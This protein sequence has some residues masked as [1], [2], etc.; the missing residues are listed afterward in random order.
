MLWLFELFLVRVSVLCYL[1]LLSALG[2]VPTLI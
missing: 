2:E 1:K